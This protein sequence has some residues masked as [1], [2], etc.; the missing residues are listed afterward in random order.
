MKVTIEINRRA[1]IQEII[2]TIQSKLKGALAEQK[3][4]HAPIEVENK[5]IKVSTLSLRKI[6][7]QTPLKF[8]ATILPRRDI[9]VHAQLNFI[10]PD[11]A[12]I[13]LRTKALRIRK[14]KIKE[15]TGKVDIRLGEIPL[16]SSLADETGTLNQRL[17]TA[18][19]ETKEHQ[20]GIFFKDTEITQ[21][22]T[23]TLVTGQKDF[24]IHA[25]KKEFGRDAE[26][27]I[28]FI[29]GVN[30]KPW[31]EDFERLKDGLNLFFNLMKKARLLKRG[32]L[33]E[34]KITQMIGEIRFEIERAENLGQE[35]KDKNML[36]A[37]KDFTNQ[38]LVKLNLITKPIFEEEKSHVIEMITSNLAE[39]LAHI[40]SNISLS[41]PDDVYLKNKT[42]ISPDNFTIQV[43]SRSQRGDH[44]PGGVIEV[45]GV[46]IY[47]YETW[48]LLQ[49][50]KISI[51]SEDSEPRG[52]KPPF[53]HIADAVKAVKKK[54]KG[55]SKEP[56]L[57]QELRSLIDSLQKL[58]ERIGYE[59][60]KDGVEEIIGSIYKKGKIDMSG[61]IDCAK[62]FLSVLNQLPKELDTEKNQL[63]DSLK[64]TLDR[65]KEESG[66]GDR[67][68]IPHYGDKFSPKN[69]KNGGSEMTGKYDPFTVIKILS[70]GLEL[71][72]SGSIGPVVVL[73]T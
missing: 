67:V 61:I 45:N 4:L 35:S 55:E 5:G 27:A 36:A 3:A 66:S 70:V 10:A 72:H 6:D 29:K 56:K 13:T 71:E 2:A 11:G 43:I 51:E 46:Q 68:I 7:L 24:L 58:T 16:E 53:D 62:A 22:W 38:I 20:L 1:E 44:E 65:G 41:V 15:G 26:P 31:E 33:T 50:L 52:I 23:P 73:E 40:K 63:V 64:E 19:I 28:D 59:I 21:L 54:V 18:I 42:D 17:I 39:I 9:W 69:M 30:A 8:V 37:V 14:G 34:D 60:P 47:N 25:A 48:E 32:K 49:P 57:V 12:K